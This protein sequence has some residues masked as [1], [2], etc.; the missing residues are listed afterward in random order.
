VLSTH[1][2][3][4]QRNH[5]CENDLLKW[6][7]PF[8]TWVNLLDQSQNNSIPAPIAKH[9]LLENSNSII[10]YTWRLLLQCHPHD[11]ICG[12][13]I[14]QVVKEMGIR[15]DQ[16]EQ[17]NQEMI[18]QALQKLSENIDT[19]SQHNAISPDGIQDIL[20]SI[21]VFNPNNSLNT[22][23]ISIKY[24]LDKRYSSIEVIDDSGNKIPVYQEGLGRR[25]LI[26][27]ILD[28]KGLKQALGMIHEG[29]VTG[30]VIRDF[31]IE[32]LESQVIINIS[33]AD[34]SQVDLNQWRDGLLQIEA[35]LEDPKVK[36]YVVQAYSD[37]EVSL[38]LI[39]EDVPA[40]GYR[41]YWIHGIPQSQVDSSQPIKLNS[42]YRTLLPVI[43]RMT[44]FPLLSKLLRR[45]KPKS[46]KPPFKIM[47]EY[48]IVEAEPSNGTLTIVD[49]RNNQVFAGL[50]QFID[51][52]DCGDLYNYCPP[53][54]DQFV[55][56]KLKYIECDDSDVYQRLMIN[57]QLIIPG[58]ISDDR[59]TRSHQMIKINIPSEVI[60]VLGMPRVDICTK[61]DNQ[62]TDHRLR[63]HFPA[64]FETSTSW[65]DG[66]FEI[67]E[68]SIERPHIDETWAEPPRP[69]VPQREFTSI[70]NG[71]ISLT[72][73][74]RGLPEVEVLSY[75]K[76]QT[77]IVLTLLR[78]VG[79]L[80][81]D[82]LT[83][84]KGQAGPMD[85]YT[86]DAQM[87]GKHTFNYS[88]IPNDSDWHHSIH[89]AQ[90]FNAPLHAVDTTIHSGI[91][92]EKSAMIDNRNK[93]FIITAIKQAENNAGL[94]LRGYNILSSPINVKLTPWR[95]FS[96]A[97]LVNLDEKMVISLPI[98]SNGEI[99]IRVDGKKISTIRFFD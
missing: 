99:N 58:S 63:V 32:R 27:M 76:G 65:H 45:N 6:V 73:A 87:L 75:E 34:H 62:A 72:I 81:R 79:W 44:Q 61:I 42:F 29:N 13:S 82:D 60:L 67:V 66:H 68:C 31:E 88:I 26:S 11:S 55:A 47:N 96:N 28:K 33:L 53:M 18:N 50:N 85:V 46:A 21:V 57:Y 17:I 20:S 56:A 25:E 7:E 37:P 30:M 83:T 51:G 95:S 36:E 2:S 41:C 8:S 22:G 14:D 3:L 5:S 49:K 78:C 35:V 38:S 59:K 4:K 40:H 92:P 70:N 43:S 10:E 98:S 24:K 69:E 91:L 64:P 94:I 19:S 90:A 23:L 54:H 15:F 86:P 84:R 9:Q 1:I 16:I 48:F 71:Q 77:D 39:A 12:T 97:Q 93:D 80:S 52:G 74:N 89:H